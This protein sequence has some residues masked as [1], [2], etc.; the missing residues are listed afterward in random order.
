[1]KNGDRWYVIFKTSNDWKNNFEYF[2][3]L[4]KTFTHEFYNEL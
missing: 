3:K 4:N 1:M 2:D